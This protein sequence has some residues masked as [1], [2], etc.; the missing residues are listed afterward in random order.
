MTKQ[1]SVEFTLYGDL[2]GITVERL[3]EI[4]SEYPADARID[5]RSEK[6]YG[7][8]GWP[9]EDREFFV[10]VWEKDIR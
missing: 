9:K 6:V 7:H 10:I 4:L 8:G 2:D 1:E 3:R 5:V